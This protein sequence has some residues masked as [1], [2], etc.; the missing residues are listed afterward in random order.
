MAKHRPEG[1]GD[2]GTLC[3]ETAERTHWCLVTFS[4]CSL[5]PAWLCISL[6]LSSSHRP[7]ITLRYV[8]SFTESVIHPRTDVTIHAKSAQLD[9]EIAAKNTPNANPGDPPGKQ[10]ESWSHLGARRVPM[11]LT[12]VTRRCHSLRSQAVLCSFLDALLS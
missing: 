11:P 9:K 5:P 1:Y 8:S 3:E 10:N 2:I 6:C 4:S 7:G 12:K